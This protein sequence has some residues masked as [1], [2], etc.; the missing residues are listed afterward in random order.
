MKAHQ[1]YCLPA[2]FA[3]AR[4]FI[5][6]LILSAWTG[7]AVAQTGC[8]LRPVP[9]P[10]RMAAA[11]LVVEAS[12][13]PQQ[14]LAGRG[15]HLFTV[16]ELTIYKVFQ[17]QLPAGGVRLA[18]PG[19]T[20]GLRREEVSS[21]AGLLPDEQGVFLLEPDPASG[22]AGLY[23]LQAGPQ[24]IIRYDV[25]RR[26]AVEPFARYASIAGALYPVLEQLA[27]QAAR[28]VRPNL[29]LA[30]P[31]PQARPAAQPGISSFSPQALTAGTGAVLTID[32][33]NFGALRGS[34]S[35]SF[36]N[37]DNGG[38]TFV[39]ANPTDY[40]LWSDTRIQLRVPSAIVGGSVSNGTGNTA[41]TGVF[42]VTNGTGE[43]GTSPT[44]LT[45][46][47]ALINLV[48]NNGDTPNRPRLIN[49][50]GQ[51]GYSLQYSPS[52]TSRAGA[53]AAF[54]R[55][56]TTW[57]CATRLRRVMVLA[58]GPEATA[59][60]GV[61]VVRFGSAVEVPS[62][63]L[64]VTNSYYSGC[65]VNGVAAFS[66]VEMD[67]TFNTSTSWQFGPALA[68]GSDYDFETVALHELGHGTQ[69][70]HLIDPP[71]VMHFSV[72]NGVNKRTLDADS[73][74]AG[75]TDV[76]TFSAS[77]PCTA[78]FPSLS[79]PVAAAVPAGCTTPL[80]VELVAFA[81]QY[82]AGR[83]TRLTWTTASETNSAFFAVESSAEPAAGRWA[84]AGRV[85]AAGSSNT[86]RTYE[87]IDARPLTGVR[88][89]RLRQTDADGSTQYSSVVAVSGEASA[90]LSLYPNPATDRLRVL[91][92][93]PAGAARLT[94]I[95]MAGRAVLRLAL[96]PEVPEVPL[97]GLRP[98][99]YVVEWTDGTTTRRGRLV[100]Q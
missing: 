25:A 33:S 5:F 76:F 52:F 55:T 59:S 47:Y 81:A 27:G 63:V 73:D 98:G 28:P 6:L 66:L 99:L 89:Y 80:P 36:P 77:N 44:A 17:G 71:A 53:E 93:R 67:Y 41:G 32:G 12:V 82:E 29:L 49:D 21:A 16:S 15:G 39:T 38:A 48:P 3:G 60:D 46:T 57:A 11:T 96:A 34:G 56:L 10:E 14:V 18:E 70:T 100:K 22:T 19:G 43:T 61:N 85:P 42:R 94:F 64:G 50:D 97:S 86:P 26:T 95:D 54:E 35:V 91:A 37:A 31:L 30:A 87:L 7:A 74:I 23:R 2:A 24:G 78:S 58:A 72:P 68:S 13:G 84:E 88:Y 20:L 45:V 62:G 1:R 8:M 92:P 9:L 75:G 90:A 65:S 51:G 79:P 83:G 4:L 40:V 69:L